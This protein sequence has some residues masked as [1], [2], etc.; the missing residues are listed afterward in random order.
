MTSWR[1]GYVSRQP[2][3]S[4]S[5]WDMNDVTVEPARVQGRKDTDR[6]ADAIA[7]F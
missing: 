5:K 7:M 6:R 1:D 3:Q 2:Q 4:G